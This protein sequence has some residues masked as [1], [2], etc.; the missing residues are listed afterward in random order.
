M[1]ADIPQD[2]SVESSAGYTITAGITLNPTSGSSGTVITITGG[3]FAASTDGWVWFDSNKDSVRDAGEP[4]ASVTTDAAGSIPSETT[5]TAPELAAGTYNV[6]ADIPEGSAVEA[7]K[8]FSY[9]NPP[10]SMSLTPASGVMNTSVIGVSGSYF[11]ANT[12]GYVWFDSDGDSVRDSEEPQV[13]V[14]TTAAGAIPPGTDLH[15]SSLAPNKTYQVRVDIPSGGS[16][17]ASASF[18]TS[19]T[20]TALI[21]TKFGPYGNVLDQTT[22]DYATMESTLDGQLP[23]QG[24]GERHY[25]LQGPVLPEYGTDIWDPTETLNI[26]DWGADMGTDLKDLC[27][28][29]GGMSAGDTVEVKASD[30]LGRTYDYPNV[31]NPDPR[32]GK[33]VICWYTKGGGGAEMPYPDGAYVPEFGEGMR[34]MFFAETTNSEGKYVFG[35]SDQHECFASNRWYFYDGEYP[36]TTGHSVKYVNR[37]NIYSTQTIEHDLT[38]AVDGNG[39]TTPSVGSHTYGEGSVVSITAE[40][41]SGWNF[42][43]WTGD[44]A[45]ADSAST[46][47]TMDA[48]KSVTAHFTKQTTNLPLALTVMVALLQPSASTP[49]PQAQPSTL[50]RPRMMAG[51]LSTGLATWLMPT[52]PLPPL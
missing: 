29:V 22:I 16:I 39:S 46:T 7:S 8:S 44:V 43:N 3:G 13:S 23:V 49:T 19:K 5:L 41:D 34:L 50:R 21:I 37:I 20:T 42:V 51:I 32:Q 33:M 35:N 2:G 18:T 11:A 10:P 47:V 26:R 15:T 17:E 12:A 27:E 4:Q 25:W 14:T 45:D 6:W 24:D 48:D 36:T 38:I 1:R 30:G 40:P 52:Q 28:L 9:I 31:Y